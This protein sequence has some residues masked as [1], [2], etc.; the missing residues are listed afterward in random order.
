MF[1]DCQ[2]HVQNFSFYFPEQ[3]VI[4][5]NFFF[6][7]IEIKSHGKPLLIGLWVAWLTQ[8]GLTVLC[9]IHQFLD[10]FTIL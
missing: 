9:Y 7:K 10:F 2:G 4:G 5:K 1:T 3:K 8:I 6:W